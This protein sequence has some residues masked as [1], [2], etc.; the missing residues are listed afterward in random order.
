[1]AEEKKSSIFEHHFRNTMLMLLVLFFL[2]IFIQ[3]FG[4]SA[5]WWE[6]LFSFSRTLVVLSKN[7]WPVW[8]ISAA[9]ISGLGSVFIGYNLIKRKSIERIEEEIYGKPPSDEFLEGVL[10]D[11]KDKR[12]ARVVELIN[13]N[14]P[15]DWKLAIIEADVILEG[16]LRAQGYDG[17]GVGEMLKG[18]E[19]SDFLTLD[20][21]WE[22]HKIRNR[23]AH[24]GSDF[25]LTEREA[26]RVITLF[27]SVFKEFQII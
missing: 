26:K 19:P 18:I 8:Q 10:E 16:L 27:E 17:E 22:A 15:S 3:Q 2:S 1:M 4:S 5:G 13:S 14:E 24:S 12:W 23:I 11:T 21:A 7:S 20:A 9:V 6:R 25:D